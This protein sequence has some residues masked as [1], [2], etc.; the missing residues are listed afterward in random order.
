[1]KEQFLMRK[2]TWKVER[3]I[4]SFF[5]EKLKFDKGTP[6]VSIFLRLEETWSDGFSLT[7]GSL[8]ILSKNPSP[9][10]S[11]PNPLQKLPLSL[12]ELL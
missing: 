12:E 9:T 7:E 1:M 3:K 2:Q 6:W 4:G 8:N 11:R 10:A 5:D